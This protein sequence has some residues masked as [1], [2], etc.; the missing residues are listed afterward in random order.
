MIGRVSRF[1]TAAI[2]YTHCHIERVLLPT[3]E[4]GSQAPINNREVWQTHAKGV[5]P[6]QQ[7]SA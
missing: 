4:P 3:R 5:Q 1:A 7:P 2:D 6:N